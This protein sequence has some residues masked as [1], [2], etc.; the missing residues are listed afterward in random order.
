MCCTFLRRSSRSSS[1]HSEIWCFL[2]FW[3]CQMSLPGTSRSEIWHF[4]PGS[5]RP[6]RRPP[7]GAWTPGNPVWHSWGMPNGCCGRF[8][9]PLLWTTTFFSFCALRWLRFQPETT[10]TN[11]KGWE[12]S[13]WEDT[14]EDP[15]E[16]IPEISCQSEN[17]MRKLLGNLNRGDAFKRFSDKELI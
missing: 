17:G 13:T 9:H 3:R 2:S 12:E 14:D 5:G 15:S 6:P 7:D 1:S 8:W 10:E 16:E 11:I 4:S